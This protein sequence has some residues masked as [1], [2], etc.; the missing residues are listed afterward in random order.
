MAQTKKEIDLVLDAAG[1]GSE[2]ENWKVLWKVQELLECPRCSWH[3]N[4]GRMEPAKV[5]LIRQYLDDWIVAAHLHWM[6][7]NFA[8]RFPTK[9][10]LVS[11]KEWNEQIEINKLFRDLNN[12]AKKNPSII[13][14]TFSEAGIA[15]YPEQKHSKYA[16]QFPPA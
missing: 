2:K 6:R 9:P 15:L 4:R 8:N 16:E 13:E 11:N 14:I 12:Y 10:N 3:A 7:H 1:D 5:D